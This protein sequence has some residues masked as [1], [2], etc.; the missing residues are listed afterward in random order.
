[1]EKNE[2]INTYKN[3]EILLK[4]IKESLKIEICGIDLDKLPSLKEMLK[5]GVIAAVEVEMDSIEKQINYE[6]N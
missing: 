4:F 6:N 3:L 1:M 2:L 5:E